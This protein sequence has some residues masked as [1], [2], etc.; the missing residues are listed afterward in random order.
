MKKLFVL[1]K[2]LEI[3]YIFAQYSREY[4]GGTPTAVQA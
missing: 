1:Q 3:T 2:I 4:R